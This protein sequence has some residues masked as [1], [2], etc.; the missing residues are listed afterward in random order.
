[1]NQYTKQ[2]VT[3]QTCD[4]EPIHIPESIQDYGYLIAFDPHTFDIEVVSENVLDLSSISSSSDGG[5]E[6]DLSK[7]IGSSLFASI[8]S[9]DCKEIINNAI[10]TAREL[11]N[12]VPVELCHEFEISAEDR[13]V[14]LSNILY[15]SGDLAV[16][17][18]EPSKPF[19][20]RS[21][22]HLTSAVSDNVKDIRA[23]ETVEALADYFSQTIKRM[24]G[25][26]RV[27][28]YRFDHNYDGE[29]IAETKEDHLEPFLGLRYPASDI[30]KQAREL[31][32][33][34]LI[35]MISSV[36]D[37]SV[38]IYPAAVTRES[39]PLDMTHSML[40]SVSPIH[41]QYLRNMGV[42][43]TMSISLLAGGELWGLIACHHY[44]DKYVPQAL[45][46]QCE[47]LAQIFAWQITTKEQQCALESARQS[48]ELTR[49]IINGV[50][51]EGISLRGLSE[52]KDQLLRFL[53]ADGFVLKLGEE[54]IELGKVP[55]TALTRSLVKYLSEMDSPKLRSI[56]S[57]YN[58]KDFDNRMLFGDT[59][60]CLYM[61]LSLQHD[62]FALWYRDERYQ[63]VNWA[64][65]PHAKGTSEENRLSPRG[66][67]ALW[68]ETVTRYCAP[69]TQTD[70][71]CAERFS[72]LF[73]EQVIAQ[74]I[75]VEQTLGKLQE[76]DRAKD[77]FLA[78]VSHELRAPLNVIVGWS[79]LGLTDNSNNLQM[80]E[81]LKIIRKNALT[82]SEL[83]NDLLDLS[84]IISGTLKLS[85]KNVNL[86]AIVSEIY[87]GFSTAARAKNIQVSRI[88]TNDLQTVL[89]DPVRIK[90]IL[91]NLV[92]NAI[93][94]TPKGGKVM[95]SA[96]RQDSS[97]ILD[98][99]DNGKGLAQE[100][101]PIIFERFTQLE[102]SHNKVG[103][104]IGLSIVKHLVEMHG[105]QIN[106]SSEG[107]GKGCTFTVRFPV[108]P[109]DL[110]STSDSVYFSE[111]SSPV[112]KNQGQGR[113]KKLRIL[114]AEDDK[115]ARRFLS[116]ILAAQD[117][118]VKTSCNGIDALRTIEENEEIFDL[119]LS[120]IGMPEM[121]GHELIK[122]IRSRD[123]EKYENLCAIAL[124]AYAYSTDRVKALKSGFNSYVTKPVDLEELLTVIES[125]CF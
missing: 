112:S 57:I 24:T 19:E 125:T 68:R 38:P 33:R 17:E 113:L 75:E 52:L 97:Y 84:R 48:D 3:L 56:E 1:M 6:D 30:P 14:P 94:F 108:S 15:V 39:G 89:G 120:D 47:N 72:K 87:E 59:A 60:G 65:A 23:F 118:Q 62:Y 41:L 36:E 51:Q 80:E 83:I 73:V 98:V 88:I 90:Q 31:Y 25:Y 114:I 9:E 67:F 82:Q 115:D 111:E 71:A 28:V 92:S 58:Q 13:S 109:I 85:V 4:Q 103:M 70:L 110:S 86:A 116:K 18:I 10:A 66:S 123:G 29:V 96:R 43:A 64:G 63:T 106:V 53:D 101:I 95:I 16:I 122:Q 2:E 40:R 8:L 34:N 76:V 35:R 81:A 12:R 26:D 61:P 22:R 99:T 117:A 20:A 79:D 45:R 54:L 37:N 93:K 42:G 91:W 121:D 55:S 100:S 27:M 7:L 11:G 74:K 105:G 32:K 119:L 69:W 46:L 77:Q 44:S 49:E 50:L 78:T 107:L 104:G 102:A 5:H 21:P 124:T